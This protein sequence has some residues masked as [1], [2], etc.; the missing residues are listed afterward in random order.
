MKIETNPKSVLTSDFKS[1][2]ITVTISS[3][4]G[5]RDNNINILYGFS[6]EKDSN[7][8]VGGWRSLIS[9]SNVKANIPNQLEQRK[10]L[11]KGETVKA[12][13]ALTTSSELTGTYYLI[14]KI[15]TL[16]NR[17]GKPWTTT[18]S[19]IQSFGPFTV[20]NTKPQFND[21]TIV[22]TN[23]GYSTLT[24]KLNLKV[25]DQISNASQLKMCIAYDSETCP[26]KVNDIKNGTKYEK[27][28]QTKLLSQV[29]FCK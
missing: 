9:D 4:T 21:S 16:E 13:F 14:L 26:V 5:I 8:P 27:Y 25:T 12:M 11:E 1:I 22:S 18:E 20:D 29:Q 7:S 2:N 3:N 23:T 10:T 28:N 19:S 17:D 6:D 15:E 24:P